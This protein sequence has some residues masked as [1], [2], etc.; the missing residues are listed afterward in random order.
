MTVLTQGE[1]WIALSDTP[2]PESNALI[3]ALQPQNGEVRYYLNQT[4]TPIGRID[5]DQLSSQVNFGAT[6]PYVYDFRVTISGNKVS[7]E[8]NLIDLSS[9]IV[10]LPKYLFLGYRNKSTLGS[11]T[12]QVKIS[13]LTIEARR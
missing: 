13:N 3:F 12:M 11:V 1:F 2:T 4:S 9:Q 10:N 5:W 7:N 8:I 6:P